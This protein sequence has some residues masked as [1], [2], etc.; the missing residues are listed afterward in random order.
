MK[1]MTTNDAG[2]R[3]G[4]LLDAAQRTPVR[5]TRNGQPV[6]IMLSAQ[7]Y[8]RLRGAAWERLAATMDRMNREGSANNPTDA[9][10]DALVANES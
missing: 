7:R 2:N 9:R 3:F 4:L 1:E 5:V 10:L 6:A 8:E